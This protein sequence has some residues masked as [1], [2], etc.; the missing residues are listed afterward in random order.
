MDEIADL[1]NAN[2][3]DFTRPYFTSPP[4]LPDIILGPNVTRQV[5]ANLGVPPIIFSLVVGSPP[6]G[7]TLSPIGILSGT[8]SASGLFDFTVRATDSVGNFAEQQCSLRV[9]AS[10]TAPSGLVAWWPG[11]GDA[12]DIVSGNDGT[13]RGGTA[14]SA[15]KVEGGFTFDSDDDGVTIPGRVSDVHFGLATLHA[16][17]GVTAGAKHRHDII[18]RS[19]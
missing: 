9:Y 16:L 4:Q 7:M 17:V 3:K 8:P 19:F 18:S 10:V 14:F 12:K 6:P 11:N 15:A 13:L 1:Y 2:L 5:S